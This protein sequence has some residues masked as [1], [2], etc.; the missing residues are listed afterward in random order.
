MAKIDS[1]KSDEPMVGIVLATYNPCLSY[2][3][4]QVNSLK[5][6]TYKNWKCIVVDDCSSEEKFR[7]IRCILSGDARF[8]LHRN[9]KN[10]GSFKTFETGLCLL[11]KEAKFVCYCDQDDIWAPT[12]LAE[13]LKAFKDESVYLVHTDQM[14]INEDNQV[15]IKS[16]WELEGRNVYEAST[17]LLM[18]RNLI[19]G[20]TTMFRREV[21]N[22]ALPFYPPR[23]S[24]IMYH[25]DMWVAMHACVHGRVIG[26][27]N[28]LVMYRQH[29]ANLVGVATLRKKLVFRNLALRA[30][31]AFR[32]RWGLRQ[33]FLD[34]LER[35][36]RKTCA[37]QRRSLSYLDRPWALIRKGFDFVWHHP[38]FFRTWIMLGV[39]YL[40]FYLTGKLTVQTK[41]A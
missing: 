34:S 11:P 41:K 33:D 35:F 18:F 27:K 17:D 19:T 39:G 30:G 5:N 31:Q 38:L 22:T 28:P 21:L 12:K 4:D 9:T 3:I 23:P 37:L 29:G 10:Q 13:Q 6:Q 1:E 2:L 15:F 26:L 20:C 32:E 7:N 14:L 24:H 36:D 16:C 40:H 8:E 25:H